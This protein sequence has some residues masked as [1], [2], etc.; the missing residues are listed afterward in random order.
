MASLQ[1]RVPS[2]AISLSKGCYRGQEIMARITY[3]GHLNRGL[4]GIAVHQSYIP[5][6][7]TEVRV[8]GGKIGKVT[9]AIFSPRLHHP[10]ALA[11]LKNEFVKPGTSVDPVTNDGIIPAEVIALPLPI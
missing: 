4:G 8:Q 10:L 5:P 3:R 9:S 6:R 2:T 7:G 11:V 1:K